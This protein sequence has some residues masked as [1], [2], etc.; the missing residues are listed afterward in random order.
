ML[1][2]T[3]L[4]AVALLWPARMIGALDGIPLDGR[5]DAV[6]IGLAVPALWWVDRGFI[7]RKFARALIVGLLGWKALLMA[8]AVPHGLCAKFTTA[9][10][11]AGEIQTIPVE[12]P[13]G[14]LRS[15]D[16]RADW[17][18]EEATAARAAEPELEPDPEP[19]PPESL[20]RYPA[21]RRPKSAATPNLDAVRAWKDDR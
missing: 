5:L 4:A 7:S 14:I 16:V 9:A 6:V 10:P 20:T 18:A 12:E 19:P 1:I 11:F 8:A 21:K 17:R 3:F 2:W 15:W 13:R